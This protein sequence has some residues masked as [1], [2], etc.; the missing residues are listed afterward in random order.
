MKGVRPV[1]GLKSFCKGP[2]MRLQ[3]GTQRLHSATEQYNAPTVHFFN[4]EIMRRE[5]TGKKT[6]SNYQKKKT[7]KRRPSLNVLS[8]AKRQE[9]RIY[10]LSE[11]K[12]NKIDKVF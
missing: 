5:K 1:P 10:A 12:R 4:G 2:G 7:T 9:I 3:Y 8:D 6:G 11:V